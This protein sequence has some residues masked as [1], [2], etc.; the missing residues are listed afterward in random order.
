[1]KYRFLRQYSVDHYVIDF[2]CP[3]L[4][5]AFEVDGNVHD[6]SGQQEY[7]NNRQEY[8]ESYGITFVRITNDE[9]LANPEKAFN[10]IEEEIKIIEGN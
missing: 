3:I 5:L 8:L 9:L 6:S 2:Y 1:M 10:K 7:D 4:K